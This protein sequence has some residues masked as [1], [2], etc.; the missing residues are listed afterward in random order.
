MKNLQL[1][2]VGLGFADQSSDHTVLFADSDK[3]VILADSD[4]TAL[5]TG[6]GETAL[7]SG[8][9]KRVLSVGRDLNFQ[10]GD[11]ISFQP[12]YFGL[13]S[14]MTSPFVKFISDFLFP[15]YL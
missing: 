7:L 4:K 2:T 14:C 5:D 3:T 8:R 12:N 15:F 11:I 9:D 10:V 13:L 6:R 1:L